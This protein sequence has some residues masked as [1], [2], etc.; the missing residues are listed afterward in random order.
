MIHE[1]DDYYKFSLINF[2]R[3]LCKKN[4]ENLIKLN[5][6]K[7]RFHLFPIVVDEY[8][9]IIDGQHRFEACKK[10]EQPIHYVID[11]SEQDHWE[12]ITEVNQAGKKHSVSDVYEMLLRSD[13]SYCLQIKPIARQ[14]PEIPVGVL[15]HYFITNQTRTESVLKLMQTKDH[16]IIN[17]DYRLQTLEAFVNV[18]GYFKIT[19]AKSMLRLLTKLSQPNPNKYFR[20]LTNKGFIPIKTWSSSSF[21]E[22]V[23]KYHNKGRHKKKISL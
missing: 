5:K 15:C 14:Y 20:E 1:T 2:N 17:F 6:T 11:Y 10:L 7:N 16:K 3:P 9:N 8:Y 13:D 18:F 21:K 19:H 12:S 22:A 4:L 23:V